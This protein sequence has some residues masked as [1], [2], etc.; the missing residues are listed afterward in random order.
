M[1]R[2]LLGLGLAL[3]LSISTALAASTTLK[4]AQGLAIHGLD[5]GHTFT[6]TLRQSTSQKQNGVTVTID[7]RLKPYLEVTLREG[8]LHLG[9]DDLPRE[10]QSSDKWCCPATAEVTLSSIDRLSTSGLASVK[11]QG[12]FSGAAREFSASGSSRIDP[13]TVAVTGN[14]DT[15]VELSGLST[16]TLTLQGANS[17]EIDVSGNSS[18]TL[19]CGSVQELDIDVSGLSSA[20]IKG[21]AT[22]VQTDCGGNSKLTLECGATRTLTASTSGLSSATISGSADRLE[23][24]ASGNSQLNTQKLKTKAAVCDASGMSSISVWITESLNASASGN[25]SI[26]YRADGNIKQTINTSGLSSVNSIQ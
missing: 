24:E 7:E 17:A 10:L 3:G 2:Q 23:T 22:V 13:I 15:E 1:K 5:A 18:L 21:N 14:H 25:S 9:F 12:S 11:P 19:D 6:V 4:S 16:I 26:R 20:S 8:I